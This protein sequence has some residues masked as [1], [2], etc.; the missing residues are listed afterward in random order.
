MSKTRGPETAQKKGPV[1]DEHTG[2]GG[3]YVIDPATGKR[4]LAERTLSREEAAQLKE[5]GNAD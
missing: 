4:K 1:R 2:R 3:S 5:K